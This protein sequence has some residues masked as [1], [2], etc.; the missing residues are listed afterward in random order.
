MSRKKF[1]SV[2]AQFRWQVEPT[3]RVLQSGP[4]KQFFKD[5]L[6]ELLGFLAQ[7]EKLASQLAS[8]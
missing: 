5:P 1:L 4:L 3:P 2:T 6:Q 8:V 7:K